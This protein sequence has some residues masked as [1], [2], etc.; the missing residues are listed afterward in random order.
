MPLHLSQHMRTRRRRTG[1]SSRCFW[2]ELHGARGDR[3]RRLNAK[4]TERP[5]QQETRE[6]RSR[7]TVQ[8]T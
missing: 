2:K 4:T 1:P 6:A 7:S 5:P 8:W 3:I